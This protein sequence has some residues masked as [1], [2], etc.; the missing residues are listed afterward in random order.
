MS[1]SSTNERH[2]SVD[3]LDVGIAC[4][5]KCRIPEEG[6]FTEGGYTILCSGRSSDQPKL[7]GVAIAL[8]SHLRSS[9]VNWKAINSRLMTMCIKLDK[10]CH[11]TVLSVYAPTFKRPQ[12]E[13]ILF[14]D[15]LSSTL[16]DIPKGDR[17]FLLGDFNARVGSDTTTW[18]DLIG[19]NGLSV[20]NSQGYMLLELCT[21]HH[22]QHPIHSCR[23]PQRNLDAPA[24]Q[25]IA[26][27]RFHHC[28][29]AFQ[30]DV[31]DSRVRRSADCWT[32]HKLVC[33]R[34]KF[35]FHIS[36]QPVPGDSTPHASQFHLPNRP[37]RRSWLE[38]WH[39]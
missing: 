9:I 29:S 8:K 31:L 32:D 34:L 2:Q 11:V 12:E 28:E 5:N 39:N 4:L 17:I 14:Y 7:E 3:Q 35:R 23:H 30:E 36:K 33:A 6:E 16:S 26:Y 18:P 21:R 20:A 19:Q 13:K 37:S 15:Q 10:N 22:H 27:D 24:I 1:D 25:K 38:N